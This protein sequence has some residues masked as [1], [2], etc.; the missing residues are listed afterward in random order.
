MYSKDGEPFKIFLEAFPTQVRFV[1]IDKLECSFLA[2]DE[3]ITITRSIVD[4][5]QEAEEQRKLVQVKQL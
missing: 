4:Q 2:V 3:S 1:Q 5:L